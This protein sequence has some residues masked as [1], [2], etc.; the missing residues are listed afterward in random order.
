MVIARFRARLRPENRL[1]F[2]PRLSNADFLTHAGFIRSGN[3]TRAG[4]L[5]FTAAP[6]R[7]LQ[8]AILRL[9]VWSR[10]KPVGPRERK[11]YRGPIPELLTDAFDAIASRIETLETPEAGQVATLM[12]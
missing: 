3:L 11:D 9:A 1:T 5:L 2:P 12:S 8:T 7:L 4:V 6:E 10:D